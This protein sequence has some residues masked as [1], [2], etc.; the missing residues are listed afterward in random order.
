MPASHE[1]WN[2]SAVIY[3]LTRI[4]YRTISISI[5]RANS[6]DIRWARSGNRFVF[7]CFTLTKRA[8]YL[9]AAGLDVIVAGVIY[10][11]GYWWSNHFSV[12]HFNT[13]TCGSVISSG[14]HKTVGSPTPYIVISIIELVGSICNL[15]ILEVAIEN[16]A[17][18]EIKYPF[19]LSFPF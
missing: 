12:N 5:D 8:L 15:I 4:F 13:C 14:F 7:H 3:G 17:T 16:V 2:S 19:P 9:F 6:A 10:H 1:I 18:S 11:F